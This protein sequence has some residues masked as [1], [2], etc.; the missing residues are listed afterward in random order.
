MPHSDRSHEIAPGYRQSRR[1][2][3]LPGVA[4]DTGPSESAGTGPAARTLLYFAA[5]RQGYG[6]L[7]PGFLADP[8]D[9]QVSSS[10]SAEK[11]S[12]VIGFPSRAL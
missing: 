4:R 6:E 7:G 12:S 2:A 9:C 3:G 11:S 1:Y 8:R 10:Y 5:V